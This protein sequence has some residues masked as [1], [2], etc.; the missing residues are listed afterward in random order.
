[1]QQTLGI[2]ITDKL[3][4]PRNWVR[5][6]VLVLIGSIMIAVSAQVVIR[7]PFS[8]VPI[9]GQTFAILLVGFL[10]GRRLAVFTTI[11]YLLEGIL[12]LPVF[13]G[14]G[15]GIGWLLGPSG[16][17]LLGFVAASGVVGYLSDQGK[18]RKFFAILSAFALGQMVI[19]LF[20]VSW[21]TVFTGWASA[22]QTG[23]LPFL[24]GDLIKALLAGGVLLGG[25][26]L[27]D[28]WK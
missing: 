27:L 16:G 14:G 22:V 15:A 12:G 2:T 21:L 18:D 3:E 19:Y 26:K 1:M 7:L 13:A 17:Y 4:I 6:L 20:G 9:T 8:P 5:D 10:F 28:L 25:W 24:I 23:I 11:A